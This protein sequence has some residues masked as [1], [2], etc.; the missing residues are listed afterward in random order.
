VIAAILLA[1]GHARRFGAPKLLQD[2]DGKPVIRWSADL[3]SLPPIAELVVVVPPDYDAIA[4][5]LHGLGAR[6]VV[7]PA[8][9][10]GIGSSIACGVTAL[11]AGIEAAVIALADEPRLKRGVL[12]QVVARYE[13]GGVS[14]VAPSYRGVPGHPVLFDRAVLAELRELSGD[15]GARGVVE[16][17]PRR[18]AV[19]EL[20]EPRPVDVDTPADLERLRARHT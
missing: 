9:R 4:R 7:N 13:D 17:D 5:A 15:S 11:G 8:A 1:A 19:L 16:R 14:V 12:E 6:F 10:E 3:L 18:V 2:L 20:D